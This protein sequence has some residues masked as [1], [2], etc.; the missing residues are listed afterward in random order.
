MR[1]QELEVVHDVG[2]KI[3][4]FNQRVTS[5]MKYDYIKLVAYDISWMKIL[6]QVLPSLREGGILYID[7]GPG[8][9]QGL[10]AVIWEAGLVHHNTVSNQQTTN[11]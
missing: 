3:T 11:G 9:L 2:G 7:H 1:L 6:P 5:D 8:D 10:L 4:I